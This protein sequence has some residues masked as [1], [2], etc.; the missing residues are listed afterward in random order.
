MIT[1]SRLNEI[2]RFLRQ[3]PSAHWCAMSTNRWA[4][5]GAASATTPS[6]TDRE[7]D[8]LYTGGMIVKTE[9]P[10]YGW[11]TTYRFNPE[12]CPPAHL[13]DLRSPPCWM[14]DRS[15]KLWAN[16]YA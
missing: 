2:F 13:A 12:Y 14:D 3:S 8:E 15:L 6:L 5:A 9:T 10:S 16:P 4:W 1:A 11:G 7:I